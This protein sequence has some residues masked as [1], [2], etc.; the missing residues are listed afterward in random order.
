VWVGLQVLTGEGQVLEADRSKS[1][2]GIWLGSISIPNRTLRMAF[3]VSRETT[4]SY[5]ATLSSL[6][7][8]AF[9]IPVKRV[10]LKE[11]KV[12]FEIPA[13][14]A[15]YEGHFSDPSLIDGA[16]KQG[17]REPAKLELRRVHKLPVQPPRRPQEP[18]KPYPY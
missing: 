15:V 17:E 5:S 4:G 9:G 7:Q 12:C 2:E 18:E 8:Q 14:G 3:E 11:D 10:T 6:D 1:L 16:L 13:I